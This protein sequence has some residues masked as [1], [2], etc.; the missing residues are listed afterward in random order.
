VKFSMKLGTLVL[1]VAAVLASMGMVFGADP[2]PTFTATTD[3]K[4]IVLTPALPA[5]TGYSI[6]V[7]PGAF[8]GLLV[9]A[10]GSVPT[11]WDWA[12]VITFGG[13]P[14]VPPVPPIPP[15]PPVPPTPLLSIG[16]I[17][18]IDETG[19]LTPDDSKNEKVAQ[20]YAQA[21]H[22]LYRCIDQ[23]VLD[24]NKVPPPALVPYLNKAKGKP[25]PYMILIDTGNPAVILWDGHLDADSLK[26]IQRRG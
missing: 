4:V 14:P 8:Q 1:V 7:T 15:A 13:A 18:I 23:N 19:T 2:A 12:G 10:N 17:V 5:G 24:Q 22:L 11:I 3:G 9:T 21:K 25:M 16:G 20:G 26:Q 6:R